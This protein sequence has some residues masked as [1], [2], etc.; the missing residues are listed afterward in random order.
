VKLT[1]E[2]ISQLLSQPNQDCLQPEADFPKELLMGPPRYAAVL[3]PL[4]VLDRQWN[5]LYIRRTNNLPEHSGQVAFPGGR[6]SSQDTGPETTALRE[7]YEE[8]GLKPSDAQILGR[9]QDFLTITNYRVTPIVAKIPWPYPLLP[10][11][12]EVSN[13]FHIPFSWLRNPANRKVKTRDL[14]PP[15]P[16]IN[17]VYFKPYQG[18]ILWGASARFTLALFDLLFGK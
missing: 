8:I 10:S 4:F 7:A 18:E 5:I 12:D 9:L 17:V 11:A 2:I 15:F 6:V 1:Q 14:P 3:I 13:I 16:P